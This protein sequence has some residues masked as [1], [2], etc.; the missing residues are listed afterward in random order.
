VIKECGK[1]DL[2]VWLYGDYWLSIEQTNK[3]LLSYCTFVL[4]ILVFVNIGNIWPIEL[5]LYLI[6]N[7]RCQEELAILVER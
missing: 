3:F 2:S 1:T 6:C 7:L 5:N 4:K